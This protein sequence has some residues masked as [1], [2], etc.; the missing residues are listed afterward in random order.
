MSVLSGLPPETLSDLK[1]MMSEKASVLFAI[2]DQEDKGFVTK[3]DMQRMRAELPLGP[4]QL[5]AVFDQ[6]DGDG[7][8]Y[9]TLKEFTEG[10]GEYLG[11]ESKSGT[12]QG[13]GDNEEKEVKVEKK[14]EDVEPDEEN[15]FNVLL[16]ELGL[17]GLVDDDQPLRDMWLSLRHDGATAD[18]ANFEQLLTQLAR[19]LQA[20]TSEQEQLE[21]AVKSRSHLQEEH[22]QRLYE[23]MDAQIGAE[24][25]QHQEEEER[26]EQQLR[27]QWQQAMQLKDQQL[28]DVMTRTRYDQLCKTLYIA[29]TGG[30][31]PLKNANI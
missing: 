4:E 23:E 15:E 8:G 30:F 11:I 25:R 12:G 31:F 14:E 26:R 18:V 29:F 27:Q 9:L 21:H 5:E 10:F 16:G 3:R 20:K 6:L 2:C 28:Q 7:N 1:P 22:L 24:R 19:D 13:E 17:L